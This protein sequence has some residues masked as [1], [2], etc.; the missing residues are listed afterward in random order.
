MRLGRNNTFAQKITLA[1]LLAAGIA[2]GTLTTAFLVLDSIS[3]RG[4]LNARLSTLADVVGKNS[5]AALSFRDQAAAIE[6]LEAFRAEPSLITACLYDS[7]GTLFAQYK[8]DSRTPTCP[9]GLKEVLAPSREFPSVIRSVSHLDEFLG[10]VVLISDVQELK[11]RREQLLLMAGIL[12]VL[13]LSMGGTSGFLLQRKILKPISD[14]SLAME[15]VRA[16]RAYNARVSISG[17]DEIA[18]LGSGFNSMLSELERREA[19]KIEFEAQLELQA[20]ND[21]LTGLPNR[22][23]FGDRLAL[24]LATADRRQLTVAMLYI[25]LDGFKLVNDSLGHPIGDS[26]LIEVAARFSA[27]VRKSDTLARIGGDEFTVI[28]S[29]L[30]AKEEAMI[31]GRTLLDTLSQP[32]DIKGH[33][34]TISAS[35][36]ISIYP[37]NALTGS[38]L[39][40]QADGAMYAA[41]R[42]GKN[43]ALYFTPDLGIQVRER[44]TLENQLRDA[45][46][47]GEIYVNYQPE[48]DALSGRLVRFEALARWNHPTLGTIPPDKFI[49]VAEESGLIIPMGA[50]I[51]E[52]ACIEAMKWQSLASYPIQVAVNVSSIQ[53]ARVLFIDEVV[54][55]LNRT[56]LRPEL[57]QL[58]LT[59]SVMIG[60]ISSTAK[61][62]EQLKS[63]GV[64]F[65]ID[66]FGTG[67]SCLSYLPSLPFDALKVDRSFV[68]TCHSTPE[69]RILVQS[70]I[71]LA[72][73]IGLRVIVEGVETA[74][75]LAVIRDL[76]GNEV[77]GYLLGRPNS[78]P[79]ATITSFCHREKQ[80]VA[81]PM[82]QPEE[83]PRPS[84]EALETVL[85]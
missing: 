54:D 33:Q 70:L 35:I 41:K 69:G 53:F 73:N 10:S 64:T 22:R 45:L 23:L 28:L 76:G 84:V 36:G 7:S 18:H 60:G 66:D 17:S 2:V 74:E 46:A 65:A 47:K 6:V 14:L 42:N 44:L 11:R 31:V 32:F 51:L 52:Q 58:E 25:D 81:E 38:E 26:L 68:K 56:G 27:R 67:Y 78:N 55:I 63:L 20:H 85:T 37:E 34:L 59:E 71:T 61:K 30:Q 8:R 21:A 80:A 40:Q 13:A 24:T 82:C 77:Q 4:S 49:P 39:M 62:M 16:E 48:F 29:S 83:R 1:S 75:Q 57:L 19:E 3:S 72:Q 9:K 79:T 43:Q 50:Y 15:K 5:T 12:L